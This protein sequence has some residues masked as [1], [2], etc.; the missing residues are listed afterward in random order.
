MPVASIRRRAAGVELVSSPGSVMI[1]LSHHV[2]NLCRWRGHYSDAAS[3]AK[4][5]GPSKFDE[6]ANGP[7]RRLFQARC[8][9]FNLAPRLKCLR[10]ASPRRPSPFGLLATAI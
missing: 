3:S 1:G 2:V 7:G 9:P 10:D 6:V 8:V 5:L 4:T